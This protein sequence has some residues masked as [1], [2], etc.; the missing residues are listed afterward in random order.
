MLVNIVITVLS[1]SRFAS[2]ARFALPFR[3]TRATGR[4]Y[5]ETR[6]WRFEDAGFREGGGGCHPLERKEDEGK[7]AAP[8]RRSAALLSIDL[9]SF[10]K[11]LPPSLSFSPVAFHKTLR[12]IASPDKKAATSSA[13]PPLCDG[14]LKCER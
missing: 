4:A 11:A 14:A 12:E 7:D 9:E 5:P 3:P 1:T 13:A 2:L 10:I 8:S 6:P